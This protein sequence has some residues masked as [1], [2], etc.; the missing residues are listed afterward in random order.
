ME[1][2]SEKK[3]TTLFRISLIVKV[4]QGCLEVVLGVLFLYVKT[5]TIALLFQEFIRDELAEN[6]YSK[7]SNFIIQTGNSIIAAGSLFIGI[8]LLSHGIVKLLLIIGV[9][10][11]KLWAYYTFIAILVAFILY[12]I[13]RYGITHSP[14]VLIFTLFD[15]FFTWLAWHESKSIKKKYY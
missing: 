7:T 6:S 14:L 2:V 3:I 15:I 1:P 8:Y 13:Y 4:T 5:D 9:I 10:K 12:Q 11:K